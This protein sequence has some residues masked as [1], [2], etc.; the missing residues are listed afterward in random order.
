MSIGRLIPEIN[1]L[2]RPSSSSHAFL[3][4]CPLR[5]AASGQGREVSRSA[6]LVGRSLVLPRRRRVVGVRHNGGERRHKRWGAPQPLRSSSQPWMGLHNVRAVV[7]NPQRLWRNRSRMDCRSRLRS[8]AAC[9][10]SAPPA[11]GVVLPLTHDRSR[12]P[13]SVLP[14]MSAPSAADE[15]GAAG[16]RARARSQA[17]A[18]HSARCVGQLDD[19]RPMIGHRQRRS[20]A[21]GDVAEPA[22]QQDVVQLAIRLIH[23][24]GEVGGK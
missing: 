6:G 13:T 9:P 23:R 7:Q 24:K 1:P 11:H 17:H 21:R 2:V 4:E 8:R 19:Q 10:L 20:T 5:G 18:G 12:P 16:V 3:D 14:F 22:A 15:P